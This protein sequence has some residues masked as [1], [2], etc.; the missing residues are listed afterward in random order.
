ML[1]GIVPAG[2][3]IVYVILIGGSNT[4]G[5]VASTEVIRSILSSVESGR[6]KIGEGIHSGASSG[7]ASSGEAS[8]GG[9]GSG[10]ADTAELDIFKITSN[11]T[12][13]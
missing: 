1:E 6:T 9:A 5:R 8:S 11:Y 12:S 3:G 2:S 7:E 13:H 10:G 4:T